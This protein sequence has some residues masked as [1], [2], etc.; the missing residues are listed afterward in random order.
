MS[1]AV[2]AI[3]D[4]PDSVNKDRLQY[5]REWRAKNR[6]RE[7]AKRR[8]YYAANTDK[9]YTAKI[10]QSRKDTANKKRAA[11][12]AKK[13]RE[14]NPS[15][16]REMNR[17]YHASHLEQ[18]KSRRKLWLEKNPN[19][20][21][22]YFK[23]NRDQFRKHRQTRRARV[24]SATIGDTN[25]I[26]KWE[27]RWRKKKSVKCYWCCSM[28]KSVPCHVDHIIPLARG[29]SHSIE[30]LCISCPKCNLS[31]NAKPLTEWNRAIE[32]PVLF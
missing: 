31:K 29:G 9:V 6:D 14:K 23:R 28:V 20:S 25:L 17:K 7:L 2:N 26:S 22:E 32:Q 5:Q 21:A 15:K 19:W 30:N 27:S 4:A 13:W 18:Q 12:A 3:Q 10:R 1:E 16:I 24:N 11:A 8:A